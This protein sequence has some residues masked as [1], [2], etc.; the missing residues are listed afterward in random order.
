MDCAHTKAIP[1]TETF[2]ISFKR[3][4]KRMK[5]VIINKSEIWKDITYRL[6]CDACGKKRYFHMIATPEAIAYQKHRIQ[7]ILGTFGAI[8][9]VYGVI[10]APVLTFLSKLFNL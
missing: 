2:G 10:V 7:Y 8:F 5:K 9:L 4:E 3:K 6:H 1:Y